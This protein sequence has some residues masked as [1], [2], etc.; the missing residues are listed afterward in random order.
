M[1]IYTYA[2]DL[3]GDNQKDLIDL[4]SL[5]WSKQGFEPIILEPQH[6]KNHPFYK[7]FFEKINFF[8]KKLLN[9]NIDTYNLNCYTRWLAYA[10]Q[11]EEKFY[12]SDYDAINSSFSLIEPDDKLHL[13]GGVCPF[14][15]SGKSS[16]FDNLCKLFI[17]ITEKNMHELLLEFEQNP[18]GS[19]VYSD[20]GFFLYNM[21]SLLLRDDI[22]ITKDMDIGHI[23]DP[24]KNCAVNHNCT[25]LYRKEQCKIYHVSYKNTTYLKD[26]YD[27]YLDVPANMLKNIV[28]NK[29][30][31]RL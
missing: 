17:E 31:A 4:W 11:P 15:A 26:N 6:A 22:K 16:Q 27:Q 19:K 8:W 20:Q 1:K 5:S 12:V 25:E 3:S 23:F 28:A 29:L 21:S 13:M 30:I 24:N 9:K 2:F 18:S 10:T 14:F 7:P